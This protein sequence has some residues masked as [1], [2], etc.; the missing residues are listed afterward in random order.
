ML[1]I[2]D[3]RARMGDSSFLID[4]NETALLYD[5]GFG[6]TGQAVCENVSKALNGRSLDFILLTHSHY[7][8]ALGVPHV[9]RRYPDAKVIAG[10]YCAKIFAKS[11]ARALMKELDRKFANSCGIYEYEDLS[12]ELRVDIPVSD[13]DNFSVGSMEFCALSLPGHTKCSFGYYLESERLLLSCETLGVFDG[14][15]NIIPSYLVGYRM[16]LDSISAVSS[17]DIDKILIPHLGLIE[18][19]RCRYYLQNARKSA[20]ET[21]R[22]IA[23]V[24][25]FGGTKEAAFELFKNKFYH[26]AVVEAYPIDAFTLNTNIMIDL[27]EKEILL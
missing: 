7:D 14:V 18:G 16:T 20:V 27:I 21:C 13:K 12:E 6:F 15:K 3:V 24:L 2:T 1:K 19:D 11:S 8:H 17:L 25:K 23:S 9:L 10:E 22:E 26:G 4:D 5:S